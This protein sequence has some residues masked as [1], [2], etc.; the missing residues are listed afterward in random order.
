MVSGNPYSGG[1]QFYSFSTS[2]LSTTTYD[3]AFETLIL[4]EP[5]TLLTFSVG[6]F[7]LKRRMTA[8]LSSSKIRPM[9]ELGD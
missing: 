7:F 5:A 2:P 9:G 8:D 4:P 1:Q 3:M 6:V